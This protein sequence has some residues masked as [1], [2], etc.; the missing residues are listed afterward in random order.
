MFAG[1]HALRGMWQT[2]V[3][4]ELLAVIDICQLS[5]FCSRKTEMAA[6]MSN[7]ACYDVRALWTPTH[8]KKHLEKVYRCVGGSQL[9]Q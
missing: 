2:V 8:V 4:S 7:L 9:W 1:A 6:I 3:A 5:V